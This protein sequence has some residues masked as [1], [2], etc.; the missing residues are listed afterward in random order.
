MKFHL[1]TI[2]N[3][4]TLKSA[5]LGYL[6]AVLHL[7][8]SDSSGFQVCP[9][10]A[11]ANCIDPCLTTA[12]RGGIAKDNATFNPHGVVLPDNAVQRARIR[13][14]RLFFTDRAEFMRLLALDI[15]KAEHYAASFGLTLVVRPNG[16]SD[17]AWENVP[18]GDH[19]SLFAAFPH[20]QFYDYTKIATRTRTTRM[21]ANYF[22]ALSYSGASAAYLKSLSKGD[23]SAP[24]AVVFSTKKGEPLPLEFLGREVVNGDDHDLIFLHGPNV[25]IGLIAKGRARRDTSGFVVQTSTI[26]EALAA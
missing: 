8:P 15:A 19:A 11:M 2:G 3:P 18:C 7:S 26:R 1:L 13:R 6:T 4:K 5:K 12:G 22:L 14:T 10:A 16:T 23:T 25:I 24:L 21:I 9:A 17:I 20:L